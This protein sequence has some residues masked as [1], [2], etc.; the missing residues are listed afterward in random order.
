MVTVKELM[1][2][3]LNALLEASNQWCPSRVHVD[4]SYF[5]SSFMARTN[6]IECT[7]IKFLDNTK[8][9]GTVGILEGRDTI[10]MDL[11]RLEERDC[12]D[13]MNINKTNARSCTWVM[14]IFNISTD[15]RKNGLEPIQKRRTWCLPSLW[16]KKLDVIHQMCACSLGIIDWAASQKKCSQEVKKGDSPFLCCSYEILPA[17]MCPALGFSEQEK[18][19]RVGANPQAWQKNYQRAGTPLLW[20]GSET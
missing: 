16:I 14:S 11:N 20:T 4:T 7:L 8:M 17:V 18:H 10:Q 19:E 9:N 1:S 3:W 6:G 15:W 5:T 12:M 2:Q 13:P